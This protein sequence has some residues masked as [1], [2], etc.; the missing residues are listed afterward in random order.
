MQNKKNYYLVKGGGPKF[1]LR[2]TP[3]VDRGMDKEFIVKKCESFDWCVTKDIYS[4]VPLHMRASSDFFWTQQQQM[5]RQYGR[6]VFLN[7]ATT[8]EAESGVFGGI[9]AVGFLFGHS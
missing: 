5:C 6:F 2:I 1:V 4:I 3:Y 8:I 9:R 7:S